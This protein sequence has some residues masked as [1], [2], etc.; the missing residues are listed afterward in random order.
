MGNV[1]NTQ[2]LSSPVTQAE[3]S[4][5]R[6]QKSFFFLFPLIN[7]A[8]RNTKLHTCAYM[9]PLSLL[10]TIQAFL[11]LFQLLQSIDLLQ[12]KYSTF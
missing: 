2:N 7:F 4:V 9:I 8:V 1:P 6:L 11:K 3:F 10:S 5:L 12:T